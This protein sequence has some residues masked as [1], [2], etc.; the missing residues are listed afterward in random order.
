MLALLRSLRDNRRLLFDFVVRDLKARYV[1]S[2]MGFFWSVI[3]PLVNLVVYYF[4]FCKVLSMR[5]DDKMPSEEVL[6]IMFAG[7]LVWTAFAESVVRITNSLV[8][9]ANLIQKVVFPAEILAPYISLSSLSNAS[10]GLPILLACVLWFAHLSPVRPQAE[11]AAGGPTPELVAPEGAE[12]GVQA[13]PGAGGAATPAA[14]GEVDPEL[15]AKIAREQA[16]QRYEHQDVPP[17][18]LRLGLG[19]VAL[20]LLLGL[21]LVFMVG[22]G[23]VLSTLNVYFRDIYH[24]VGV[25]IQV[26]MFATP[27]F[28]PAELVSIAGYGWVLRANPMHWLIESYR[29]VLLYGH[30]P[31]AARLA[32]FAAVAAGTFFLGARFFRAHRDKFPDLL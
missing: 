12:G 2:S 20:P 23:Y 32:A 26:W 30:F 15:A 7:I 28:Y 29:D 16:L 10:F 31:P 6:L 18:P 17:R 25:F 4:V 19:I 9:N 13:A 5:W 3:F 21:Q 1:G 8:E 27:I 24:L 11:A 22:L 14:G